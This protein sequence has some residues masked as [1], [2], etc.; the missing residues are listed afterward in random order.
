MD[1][2]A[3][4]IMN[5]RFGKDTE[6]ALA[7][8]DGERP[9]VRIVDAYYEDGCFYAITHALSGKMKQI[10]QNPAVAVCGQ[11]FTGR[12]VGEN[13]GWLRD[14]KNKAIL[15]KLKTAFAAWYGNGHIN[16]ADHNTIILKIRLTDGV[17]MSHGTRYDL[18]FTR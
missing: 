8:M 10:A 16:E 3:I 11:W 12:G 4:E 6:L 1:T 2:K 14:E 9:A 5:E 18:D 15:R 7:T 13:L 17:L